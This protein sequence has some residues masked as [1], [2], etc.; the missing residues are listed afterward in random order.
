M[1]S[2]MM[3]GLLA[4]SVVASAA[5]AAGPFDGSWSGEV[6]ETIGPIRNCV[7]PM[8]G[9]VANN[10]LHGQMTIGKFKPDRHSR[11]D[12]TGRHF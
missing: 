1:R 2:L 10:V 6:A 5:Q 8:K 12:C 7:G 9:T 3:L 11:F 4:F